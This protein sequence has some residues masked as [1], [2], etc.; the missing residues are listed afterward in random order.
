[1]FCKLKFIFLG[2]GGSPE[3]GGGRGEG[4]LYTRN[5][6]KRIKFYRID[7]CGEGVLSASEDNTT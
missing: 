7:N 3:I 6:D 5:M 1:V 2:A 4:R